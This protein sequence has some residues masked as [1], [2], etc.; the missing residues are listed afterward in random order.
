MRLIIGKKI[1]VPKDEF[2]KGKKN[3]LTVSPFFPEWLIP[4]I[5]ELQ[6]EMEKRKLRVINFVELKETILWEKMYGSK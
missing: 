2:G 6:S 3:S 1:K 5:F 4:S